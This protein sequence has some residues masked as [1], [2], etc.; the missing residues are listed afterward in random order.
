M[1]DKNNNKS[2]E[3][4]PKSLKKGIM[5]SINNLVFIWEMTIVIG[6]QVGWMNILTS[7]HCT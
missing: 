2:Q 6:V 5:T 1:N 7:I 4:S 3:I